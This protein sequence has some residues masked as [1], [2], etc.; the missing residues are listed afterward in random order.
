MI[1]LIC[2]V[3]YEIYG[4]GEGSLRELVYEPAQRLKEI[5]LRW[6]QRFVVFVEVAELEMIEAAGA[7]PAIDL[8]KNQIRDFYRDGFE[9]GLH[10][11]PW[12]YNARR[13]NGEWILD[14]TEYNLCTLPRTRIAQTIGRGISYL[15]E[16]LGGS[17]FTPLSHRAGHLL[18]QN[19]QA[20]AKVLAERGI[21]VDSSVYKGGLWGQHN[22]DYRPAL[23]NG[24]YWKF[25]DCANLPDPEGVL[26]ELPIYT[27]M[28]PTWK[29]FTNKR[30][31]LQ[32][33]GSSTS[34]AGKKMLSRMKDFLRYR[35]P[36]KFDLCQM[37]L[38]E[39]IGV[40][41]AVLMED[42][43]NPTILRPIVAIG[44]TKDLVDV[45]TL[46]LF[47]SYLEKKRIPLSAFQ[48]V[49]PRCIY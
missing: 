8:I 45:E 43:Q 23:R 11:H 47:L 44:H 22:L 5:F 15:R 18:F 2:T 20:A 46:K 48:S 9:L 19:T 36:L 14:Y 26:L 13:K 40:V 38:K 24:Y 16:I 33:K 10:L 17:D 35:Y 12:W 3:D 49:Y 4:N 30:I 7:D 41:D 6:N 37:S 27:Q 42:G 21:K 25:M 32:P 39:L 29:M 28:V 1:E 31:G 34:Q